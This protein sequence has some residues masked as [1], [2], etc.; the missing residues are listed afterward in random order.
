M[1][2]EGH[3]G[4]CINFEDKNG[5]PYDKTNADY[6]KGYCTW[7]KS[8][9]YPDDQCDSHYRLR[10]GSGGGCYITTIICEVLDQEDT[11]DSLETLRSFRNN[12]LQKDSKY[13]GILH[14]YDAVGPKIAQEL[15]QEEKDFVLDLYHGFIVP[16]ISDIKGKRNAEAVSKYI[17]MTRALEETYGI[18]YENKIPVTYDY[19]QGGHG[20][21]KKKKYKVVV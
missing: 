1:A 20:V 6:I 9:Y 16:I 5:G 3:C 7:F 15:R 14:E 17:V 19:K 4:S 13:S 21:C 2:Y 18:S 11:C 12:V 10:G 8:Y